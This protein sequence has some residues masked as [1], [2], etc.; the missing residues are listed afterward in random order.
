MVVNF[1]GYKPLTDYI[2]IRQPPYNKFK[3]VFML[4]TATQT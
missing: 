4:G 3:R 1:E 2:R